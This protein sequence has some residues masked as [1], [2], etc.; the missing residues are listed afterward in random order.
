MRLTVNGKITEIEQET[1]I[2]DFLRAKNVAEALVAVEHNLRWTKRE[3]WPTVILQE[4]DR[5]EVVRIMAGGW[6]VGADRKSVV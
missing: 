5:L 1:S 6:G 4:N 3:E 2:A